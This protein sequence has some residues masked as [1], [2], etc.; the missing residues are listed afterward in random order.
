[1]DVDIVRY[2]SRAWDRLVERGNEWTV[3]VSSEQVA[4]A[5]RGEV[6]V[7]LT[8]T[9]L[10]P[11]SWLGDLA[12]ADVLCL[13]SGGGQQGPLFAAA[14]ASVTV[15]DNSPSQLAQDRMVAEREGLEVRT[16][17]GTMLDLSRFVDAAFDLIF[18]P[19]SNVF[20][21]DVRPV[22]RECHRVLR[23]GGTLL[24]GFVNPAQYI[25]DFE[26]EERGK[27]VVRHSLPYSDRDDLPQ[28]VLERLLGAGE[29]LE[30]GHTLEHQIGGQTDAGLAIVG[31]YEDSDPKHRLCDFMPTFI[32]T[33]AVRLGD[34]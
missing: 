10:V 31:F 30:F 9:R 15:F 24:A 6:E 34:V 21:P 26:E 17:Q 25:F 1:M 12:G 3:P 28:E 11:Q 33:R 4:S 16:E 19:V 32:A 23:P 14:G 18:H 8:P 27:L 7:L 29:P 5:R 20:A 22:W 2:N 13:A